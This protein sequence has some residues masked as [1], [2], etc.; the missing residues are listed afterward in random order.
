MIAL[1]IADLNV[2]AMPLD[3]A[4]EGGDHALEGKRRLRS[5]DKETEGRFLY[6][7]RVS[8][9]ERGNGKRKEEQERAR[10]LFDRIAREGG[11]IEDIK[12]P[13]EQDEDLDEFYDAEE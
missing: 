5:A 6:R 12:L 11:D 8:D 7:Q 2:P 9:H 13:L 4:N 3:D 10:K 1:Y